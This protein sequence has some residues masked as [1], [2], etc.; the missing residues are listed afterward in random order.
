MDFGHALLEDCQPKLDEQSQGY[1]GRILSAGQSMTQL[2]DALLALSRLTRQELRVADVDLGALA[3]AIAEELA[4][5]QP[6]RRVEFAIAPGLS[7]RGDP[8]LLRAVLE[9]LLGNAWKYTGKHP[10]ARIEVGARTEAGE[11]V[12]FVRDDGAGFEMSR[13]ER[14]FAPFQRLHAPSDFPGTGIGLA[15]VA[16]IVH[17]HGGRIWAEARPEAGATFSFT[18]GG[19]PTAG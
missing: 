14:L 3:R 15:T 12:Y 11:K 4:G 17:R 16:R 5:T 1:L 10:S 8:R 19:P 7:A 18:L 2:V 6:G 9:N 13:A